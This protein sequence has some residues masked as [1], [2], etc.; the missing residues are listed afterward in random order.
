MLRRYPDPGPG[1]G[2]GL[3]SFSTFIRRSPDQPLFPLAPFTVHSLP[4]FLLVRW[5]EEMLGQE[6]VDETHLQGIYG[7]ALKHRVDAAN[8]SSHG[9]VRTLDWPSRRSGEKDRP[10]WCGNA[11]S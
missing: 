4:F 7:F 9:Y 3:L 1:T 2:M 8:V 6:V 5:F 11:F 10:S